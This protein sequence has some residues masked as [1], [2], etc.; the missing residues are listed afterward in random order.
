MKKKTGSKAV[1]SNNLFGPP[2]I[3]AG[4]DEAAY[5]ALIGRVYA[6][7]KPVDVIDEMLIED[8]VA[9]EWEFL[10]WSRLKLSLVQA[11]A[12]RGLEEFLNDNMEYDLYRERFEEDL[13]EILNDN[14]PEDHAED[15]ERLA[16]DCAL[17]ETTA[18]DKV[19]K[20]LSSI[21]LELDK[22]LDG[23]RASKAEELVKEY[24]RRDSGAVALIDD[25]LAKAGETIDALIARPVQQRLEY[26]ERI[27]RLISVAEARRNASLREI[28]RRRVALGERLRRSVQEIEERELTLIETATS[29]G[30]DAA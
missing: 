8:L 5:D 1:N 2:P 23:A 22:L 14:L 24:A 6:A 11:C 13:T 30:K 9:S 19:N 27:D 16:R 3:L 25:L 10:R 29:K 28:D 7:V 15:P 4:E 17:D 12:S 20:I 18:V 26:I 21:D